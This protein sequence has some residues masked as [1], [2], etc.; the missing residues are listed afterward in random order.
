MRFLFGLLSTVWLLFGWVCYSALQIEPPAPP[1]WHA[2]KDL[3]RVSPDTLERDI[4]RYSLLLGSENL[5]GE[6]RAYTHSTLAT[7]YWLKTYFQDSRVRQIACL[8]LSLRE[9]F[10]VL[11]C[12]PEH[13]KFLANT[14]YR[15]A[16]LNQQLKRYNLTNE[17]YLK[18]LKLDPKDFLIK[19]RYNDFLKETGKEPISTGT[20][21]KK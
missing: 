12:K 13:P 14:Y 16:D 19:T 8:E 18:A 20:E 4:A 21:A 6:H 1:P 15:I 11:Q 9:C 5:S 7:C 17:Y 3:Q 2:A 10:A